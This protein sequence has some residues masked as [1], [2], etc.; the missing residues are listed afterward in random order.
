MD[1]GLTCLVC[2]SVCM[3]AHTSPGAGHGLEVIC[4]ESLGIQKCLKRQRRALAAP[5]EV[6]LDK[7]NV[8]GCRV[9]EHCL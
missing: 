5:V 9:S 2:V 7:Q 8:W 6:L 1:L 3:H 4:W